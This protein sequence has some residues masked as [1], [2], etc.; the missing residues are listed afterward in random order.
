MGEGG[1]IA[2]KTIKITNLLLLIMKIMAMFV[3]STQFT[4]RNAK[5][6][7]IKFDNKPKQNKKKK[8]R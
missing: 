8:N 2:I 7:N 1:W 5:E 4:T 3:G 6:N